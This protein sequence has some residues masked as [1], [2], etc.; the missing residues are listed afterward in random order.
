LVKAKEVSC[1]ITVSDEGQ[2]VEKFSY[3]PVIFGGNHYR[4]RSKA[5]PMFDSYSRKQLN[6][7]NWEYWSEYKTESYAIRLQR[8]IVAWYVKRK[9]AQITKKIIKSNNILP[10]EKIENRPIFGTNKD[11]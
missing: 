6:D 2:I 3:V 10:K 4:R 1:D 11:N 5:Y 8:K 7:K 9:M